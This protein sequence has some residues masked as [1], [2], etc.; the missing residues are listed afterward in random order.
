MEQKILLDAG[1]G[2]RAS[3]RLIESIFLSHFNNPWLAPM[4]DGALLPPLSGRISMSTD[5]YTVTPLFFPGGGIGELAV[6]GTVNDVAAMGAEPLYIS[7]GFIIEEGLPVSTLAKVV[8]DMA[9][10]CEK[11]NVR[12]VTGDTKVVP[13]GA[14]DKLFINTAGIGRVYAENPPSGRNARPGDAVLLSGSV[15]DHGLAVLAARED[16]SFISDV[17][18]DTAPLA[19]MIKSVLEAAGPVHVVR[20]PTRGGLATT[21]NEIAV[22]SNVCVE[23]NEDAI[24]INPEVEDG[25]SFMGLDPLYLANEGKCVFILPKER[26]EAALSAMRKNQ[27]GKSAAII[28]EVSAKMPGKVLM[29]TAIGGERILSMLEGEPL[30]RIC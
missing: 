30:P 4:D 8:A 5:S 22:Q 23:I 21:L 24:P 14:C 17:R 15:G 12:V 13:V 6:N 26:A 10:A 11:A 27:Y 19:G 18:S 20:D 16:I 1:S 28:G 3:Q 29:R 9:A 7:A 2:G 25:C